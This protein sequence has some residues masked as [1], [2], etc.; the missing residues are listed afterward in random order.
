MDKE[1]SA[2]IKEGMDL[3]RKAL[4]KEYDINNLKTIQET[5][6]SGLLAEQIMAKL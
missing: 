1:T 6:Q 4:L 2:K 3:L 5:K